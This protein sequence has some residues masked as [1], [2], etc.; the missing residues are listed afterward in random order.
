MKFIN[1]LR[2]FVQNKQTILVKHS[3]FECLIFTEQEYEKP[4]KMLILQGLFVCRA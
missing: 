2:F 3:F 4:Y 1:I